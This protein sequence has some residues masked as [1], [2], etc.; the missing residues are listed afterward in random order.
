MSDA[1]KHDL[2]WISK[3]F[4]K[5][6]E[7]I[8]VTEG[9]KRLG[10]LRANRTPMNSSYQDVDHLKSG[11]DANYD[12]PESGVVYSWY[13]HQN[14]LH[15]A[16]SAM[17][18]LIHDELR[19]KR[20]VD[21]IDVGSGTGAVLWGVSALLLA[22]NRRGL[23]PSSPVRILECDASAF[24]VQHANALWDALKVQFGGLTTLVSRL[25]PEVS[26]WDTIFLPR[27]RSPWI[28]ASYL[29]HASDAND[30]SMANED[31]E[32]VQSLAHI[33]NRNNVT[34]IVMWQSGNAK[35]VMA[36][37]A[38]A[39]FV[40]DG[41]TES[42]VSCIEDGFTKAKTTSDVVERYAKIH[43]G[44][45]GQP[46]VWRWENEYPPLCASIARPARVDGG[47]FDGE[48]RPPFCFDREQQQIIKTPP[49]KHARIRGAAGSGKTVVL[50]ERLRQAITSA[51]NT[52]PR[53]ILITCFNKK[54]LEY[55]FDLLRTYP[56]DSVRG[57]FRKHPNKKGVWEFLHD[58]VKVEALPFDGLPWRFDAVQGPLPNGPQGPSLTP[59]ANELQ[60][61]VGRR[62][63]PEWIEDEL[64]LI[65]CGRCEGQ[66]KRYL[67]SNARRGRGSEPWLTD[68]VRTQLFRAL[69]TNLGSLSSSAKP[70]TLSQARTTLLAYLE[71]R[72]LEDRATFTDVFVDEGQDL[73]RT[74]WRVLQ[75]LASPEA[76]WTICF[77]PTQAIHTGK[78]LDSPGGVISKLN[79]K[80]FELRGA[81]RVPRPV[82]RFVNL[83]FDLGYINDT[84]ESG[85]ET[86]AEDRPIRLEP[87]LHAI[88]GP[89]PVI[90]G[91]A[92]QGTL[93]NYLTTTLETYADARPDFRDGKTLIADTLDKSTCREVTER[94][95]ALHWKNV[96]VESV[97]RVKGVEY[98]TVIWYADLALH[99]SHRWSYLLYVLLTRT[100]GLLVIAF[101]GGIND[102]AR[103][104]L[105]DVFNQQRYRRLAR[106]LPDEGKIEAILSLVPTPE[107][108]PPSRSPASRTAS[109]SP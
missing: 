76:A 67:A 79:E 17:Y 85:T 101:S 20:P 24:M 89:R 58:A 71:A 55:I 108:R 8:L 21:I 35:S 22:F 51:S 52:Y 96:E 77:D 14:R 15:Q 80:I 1:V 44:E 68:S 86:L 84:D 66:L 31:G 78:V 62:L 2:E 103:R 107:A 104:F 26:S 65:I 59:V 69:E 95:N 12:L 37:R 23:R 64:R 90:I 109:H 82:A 30:P 36:R 6:T 97:L 81:Y 73:L 10:L 33:A 7:L 40:A 72:S 3:N 42:A 19:E 13:Y 87:R 63:D 50:V 46:G 39:K 98:K 92:D 16:V 4:V 9:E 5:P 11:I 27:A 25:Q 41:W 47:L 34:R 99:N 83:L 43:L 102:K 74:D 100:R 45:R 75:L 94:L 106:W 60:S 32:L 54:V 57:E 38:L 61:T 88:P 91:A 18:R 49:P 29:L 28:T 93:L 48:K 105:L 56:P 53:R 70:Q